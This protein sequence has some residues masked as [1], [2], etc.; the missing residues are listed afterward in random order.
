[1][2]LHR[3]NSWSGFFRC[4]LS[5]RADVEGLGKLLRRFATAGHMPYFNISGS[6]ANTIVPQQVVIDDK[7]L[8]RMTTSQGSA[9]PF[10]MKE[11]AIRAMNKA[12][13]TDISLCF[14]NGTTFHISG[15][16][17][18]LHND[19][20]DYTTPSMRPGLKVM[21]SVRWA[22]R[23]GSQRLRR[24]DWKPP[25]LPAPVE[26]DDVIARYSD[27]SHLLGNATSLASI[28]DAV[29]E[30]S[31]APRAVG[32]AAPERD[33]A[34]IPTETALPPRGPIHEL[35]AIGIRHELPATEVIHE[36][37]ET[38]VRTVVPKFWM[39]DEDWTDTEPRSTGSIYMSLTCGDVLQ[40]LEMP[41][42][43]LNYSVWR[44]VR[45][46]DGKEG[47]VPSHCLRP[48]EDVPPRRNHFD[49]SPINGVFW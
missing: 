19:R 35:D 3:I 37:P 36:L 47:W 32:S 44:V 6:T 20:S 30:L 31:S 24:F 13:K 40:V 21:G 1:M 49:A 14:T 4:R 16:P 26:K 8:H 15:F 46:S 10:R 42:D 18:C 12:A 17:R 28:A 7:T 22:S 45:P 29:H 23:S 5:E 25:N 33:T 48:L 41:S 9:P 27:V 39:A 38:E 43:G 11:V 2:T 34:D